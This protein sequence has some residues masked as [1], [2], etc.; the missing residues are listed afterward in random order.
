[1]TDVEISKYNNSII[2]R[3]FDIS[4]SIILILFLWPF[5]VALFI[6]LKIIYH[7]S[8]IFTQKRL[9]KDKKA[10]T[11][12]KIRTMKKGSAKVQ[13]KLYL[14]NQAPPPMFKINNDPRFTKVG[15]FL[16]RNG[17]DELPQLINILIGN[18]SLIGPRPLP[19]NEAN[20]LNSS[21]DFRYKVKPGIISKWALSPSRYKSLENWKKLEL[22]ELKDASLKN[23]IRLLC[24]SIKIVILKL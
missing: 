19:V 13:H 23:D 22:S 17:L 9:G 2:Q 18:M 14:L 6:F 12:F 1:M 4:I 11:I 15:R 20:K 10:F 21:W 8:V 7:D 5:L 16:S 24:L 3:L